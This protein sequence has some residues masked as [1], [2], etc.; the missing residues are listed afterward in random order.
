MK[1]TTLPRK[2]DLPRRFTAEPVVTWRVW[3]EL[4]KEYID[5]Y[6]ETRDEESAQWL[7][8]QLEETR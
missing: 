1:R 6:M 5:P 2:R 4:T 3:D 8:D 7:A